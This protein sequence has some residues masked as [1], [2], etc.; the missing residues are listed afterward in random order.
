MAYQGIVSDQLTSEP[1]EGL[2]EVIIRLGRNVVVLE[3][4]FPVEGD[5][6]GL[7]LSLLH[8]DLVAAEDNRDVLANA[9]EIAFGQVSHSD[10]RPCWEDL[11]CQLGT[12]L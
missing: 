5:R 11:R 2:L 3:V 8:I 10:P 1:E 12:F 7:D 9:G 6:L 4:L